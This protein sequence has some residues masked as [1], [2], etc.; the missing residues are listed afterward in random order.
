MEEVVKGRL[1]YPGEVHSWR[2]VVKVIKVAKTHKGRLPAASRGR[3]YIESLPHGGRPA[4]HFD[5]LLPREARSLFYLVPYPI[6]G[7]DA[8]LDIEDKL[9]GRPWGQPV[10]QLTTP[11]GF[12]VEFERDGVVGVP[13]CKRYPESELADFLPGREA[14]PAEAATGDAYDAAARKRLTERRTAQGGNTIF[15]PPTNVRAHHAETDALAVMRAEASSG[16]LLD[17][18]Y[19][20]ESFF[21]LYTDRAHGRA[22]P[23]GDIILAYEKVPVWVVIV[24]DVPQ[25]AKRLPSADNSG[26]TLR[27]PDGL[28]DVTFILEDATGRMLVTAIEAA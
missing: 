13:E 23:D 12:L 21:T 27:E 5:R 3:I 1:F 28:A 19:S 11:Q 7:T 10:W 22:G 24:H 6:R 20:R 2:S 14:F 17:E 9:G 18:G 26:T 15:D 8:D 25:P 16:K 4:S